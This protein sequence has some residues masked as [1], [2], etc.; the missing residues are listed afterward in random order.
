MET[1]NSFK[2]FLEK[3]GINN[4]DF[5]EK[6]FYINPEN[7]INYIFNSS[8]KGIEE[9]DCIVLIGIKPET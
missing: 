7:K 4:Y 8:I 1:I 6:P 9:T 5:R 2:S 3:I